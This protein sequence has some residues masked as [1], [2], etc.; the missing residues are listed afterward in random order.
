MRLRNVGATVHVQIRIMALY[1]RKGDMANYTEMHLLAPLWE[2][3]VNNKSLHDPSF[4]FNVTVDSFDGETNCSL[5]NH[6]M[7]TR[8]K[9]PSYPRVDAIIAEG[10]N[11]GPGTESARVAA[12]YKIPIILTS[13]NPDRTG[14]DYKM[15][16]S[17]NT[18]F[19]MVGTTVRTFRQLVKSYAQTGVKSV[20]AV[21]S[22]RR[23]KYNSHSCH[24]AADYLETYG[25]E[26]KGKYTIELGD[27]TPRVLEIINEIKDLNP[28][29]VLWCDW[30]ACKTERF[31]DEFF[32]LKIFKEIDY[33]PKAF[34]MLD[35]IN[36]RVIKDET[37]FLYV[38]APTFIND[39][40]TGL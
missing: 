3:Y 31:Y 27:S 33:L 35:C 4:P 8:I 24:G 22:Q 34:S 5:I 29:A 36:S 10:D 9:D 28:D 18:S 26:V 7:E 15:P 16:D 17:Q 40:V 2:Q 12:K 37:L 19:L 39:K 32:P 11:C 6:I 38:T 20:I 1:N 23:D 14:D 21:G 25:V 13:F 30:R